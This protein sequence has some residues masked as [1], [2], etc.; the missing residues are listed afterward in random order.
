VLS[1]SLP[2]DEA[3]L[4]QI[5]DKVIDE[6]QIIEVAQKEEDKGENIEEEETEEHKMSRQLFYDKSRR[7]MSMIHPKQLQDLHKIISNGH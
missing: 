6:D 1:G 7:S 3:S 4:S 2:K 5:K